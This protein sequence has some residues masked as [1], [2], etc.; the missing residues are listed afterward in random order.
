MMQGLVNYHAGLAAEDSV[1]RQYLQAGY[2]VLARRWRGLRGE[3]DMVLGRGTAIVFVEVKKSRNF[4][5]ASRLLGAAQ[6][7]RIYQTAEQYLATAPLG[8]NTPSRVDVALVDGFGQVE[9]IENALP[10]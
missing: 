9:I 3:L 4:G 10:A 1:L 8:L 7:R 2:C 5:S 6:L